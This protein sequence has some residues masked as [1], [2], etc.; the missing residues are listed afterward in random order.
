M[1]TGHRPGLGTSWCRRTRRAGRLRLRR[2]APGSWASSSSA[3]RAAKAAVPTQTLAVLPD[4]VSDAQVA[5]LPVAG[6]TAL[7]ASFFEYRWPLIGR[8]VLVNRRL[9]RR[10]PVRGPPAS[11]QRGGAHATAVSASAEG[12]GASPSSAPTR[13]CTSSPPRA[14]ALTLDPSQAAGRRVAERRD[15]PR[16]APLGT[17]V[18]FAWS[19]EADVTFPPPPVPRGA[20]SLGPRPLLFP[21]LGRRSGGE[22]GPRAACAA[23]RRR[24]KPDTQIHH[25]G[26]WR[27]AAAAHA[28]PARTAASRAFLCSMSTQNPP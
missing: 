11:R 25:E 2:W 22:L 7:Y 4:A 19:D 13:S 12:P 14:T 15:P 26:S 16:L 21:E 9:G 27:D 20:R 6:L 18:S 28:R 23:R 5:T 1:P 3:P 24:R 8:R 17:V 10:R